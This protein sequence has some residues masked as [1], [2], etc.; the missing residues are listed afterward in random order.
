MCSTA[1]SPPPIPAPP[2][3]SEGLDVAA[4]LNAEEPGWRLSRQQW[5]GTLAAVR[6]IDF[7]RRRQWRLDCNHVAKLRLVLRMVE[8]RSVSKHGVPAEGLQWLTSIEQ[9]SALS[10]LNS[11]CGAKSITI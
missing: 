9:Q 6:Q 3:E 1:K 4:L 11:I 8:D 2:W 7:L 5:Y 10:Q